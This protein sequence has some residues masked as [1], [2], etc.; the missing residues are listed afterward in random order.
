MS[1]V[2]RHSRG[3]RSGMFGCRRVVVRL[4][5]TPNPIQDGL[6]RSLETTRGMPM[7]SSFSSAVVPVNSID[8]DRELECI[9]RCSPNPYIPSGD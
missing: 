1:G 8:T 5:R 3:L 4:R 6:H 9:R 7:P 2:G